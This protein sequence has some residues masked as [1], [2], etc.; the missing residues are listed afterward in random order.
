MSPRAATDSDSSSSS[1]SES[2][3]QPCTKRELL[4]EIAALKKQ[5]GD[6][7]AK[8]QSATSRPNPSGCTHGIETSKA[9][10]HSHS[11]RS[12]SPRQRT[13]RCTNGRTDDTAGNPPPQK[14]DAKSVFE[15]P[16]AVTK[17]ESMKKILAARLAQLKEERSRPPHSKGGEVLLE[18]FM[19]T[20]RRDV[21]SSRT[22][23]LGSEEATCTSNTRRASACGGA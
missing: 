4:T 3:S 18:K 11:A 7:S 20:V 6:L 21:G 10:A 5:L 22:S 17:M 15:A 23:K 14:R 16:E 8:K 9:T 2:C 1:D 13:A 19:T 12:R